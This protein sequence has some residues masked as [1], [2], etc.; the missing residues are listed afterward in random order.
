[1][2][3]L[4]IV[5]AGVSGL[6]AA[7]SLRADPVEVSIFEKSRGF[8]GRAASRS[9]DSVR[10]D[11]GA[12][13]IV[14]KTERV[15][16]LICETLST[17]DLVVISQPI[18]SFDRTGRLEPPKRSSPGS[19][20]DAANRFTYTRG[21]NTIGKL[22]AQSAGAEVHR[23]TRIHSLRRRD[24]SWMLTDT[25]TQPYGPFDAVLLTPPAP[26]TQ[27]ILE[28]SAARSDG[29]SEPLYSLAGGLAA[30]D[31]D[32]QFTYILGYDRE[33]CPEA[34]FYG[35]ANEDG[36]HDIAWIGLEHMKP[37][38]VPPGEHV[39]VIQMS[40][41][42]TASRVDSDPDRYLQD[43]KEMAA[44]IL[45]ADFRRPSWYDTQRWRYS[46]PS[47][48]ADVEV[49]DD[50]ADIGLFFAGDYV[51]GTGRVSAAIETG[52]EA[53]ERVR[54]HHVD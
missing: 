40:G 54:T 49:L 41:S 39:F 11:H 43:V 27:R 25:E 17:D 15:R 35:A 37:E 5:G 23:Q 46:L 48:S 50:G 47:T 29:T 1:M 45:D 20:T 2:T 53:A 9:K 52:F 7:W 38:R 16:S 22:L 26:Q 18:V 24:E 3:H 32:A 19:E 31:Y 33:V 10:Y 12:N 21:I 28:T 6:T 44:E 8:S 42:W 14:P 30:A 36:G 13:F 4:A 51:A 34:A